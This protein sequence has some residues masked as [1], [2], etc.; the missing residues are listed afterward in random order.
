M[1]VVSYEADP[2]KEQLPDECCVF[3]LYGSLRLLCLMPEIGKLTNNSDIITE[4]KFME[5]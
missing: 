5:F 2:K 3:S 4:L 1:W